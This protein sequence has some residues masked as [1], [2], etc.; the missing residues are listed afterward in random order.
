[1][2]WAVYISDKPHSKINFPIGMNQGIWGVKES[3]KDTITNIKEGDIV[4]FVYAIS[5]LKAEGRAPKG[6]SR[7][8]KDQLHNFRGIVQSITIGKVTKSYYESHTEVWPDDVYPHRFEFD[9]IEVH[10]NNVY[11]GTEFFNEEF[12]EAVRYSAC[13]QGSVTKANSI[14]KLEEITSTIDDDEENEDLSSGY[15]GKPILRLHKSRER[16]SKLVKLKKKQIIKD[17]GKLACEVCSMD[18]KATYGDL[19]IGFA[20]CH[21]KNPLSLRE[22]NKETKLSD[23]AIVC[24]NCHRML[25]RKRP[26]LKIE[27]LKDIYTK[28]RT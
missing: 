5:W 24:S 16:S 8:S 22:E 19:G 1:M 7:V 11:F 3:K 27:A 21:H 28:Q 12:V 25:H 4:A 2:I 23:L 18:F 10:D 9:I 13:T 6:F 17:T 20:E 15:E 26:W 14:E